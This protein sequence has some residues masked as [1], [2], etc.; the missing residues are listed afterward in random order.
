MDDVADGFAELAAAGKKGAAT[1]SS[2]I[3]EKTKSG[4]DG[5]AEAISC[6]PDPS[7]PDKTR[8]KLGKVLLDKL[9]TDP[10]LLA[11]E[12]ML[13]PKEGST[14]SG[15]ELVRLGKKSVPELLGLNR[16]DI[17]LELNGVSLGSLDAIRKVD[18]ALRGKPNAEIVYERDGERKILVLERE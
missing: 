6:K 2:K 15:L 14:G 13:M 5:A 1:V 3:D 10:K 11:R 7:K 4:I 18:E 8:C 17:L 16:N 12:I 9:A